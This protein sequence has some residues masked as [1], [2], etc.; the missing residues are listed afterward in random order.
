MMRV[1]IADVLRFTQSDCDFMRAFT[2]IKP[3]NAKDTLDPIAIT[4]CIIANAT[5]LGINKISDS[6]DLNYQ[7]MIS[8]MRNFIRLETLQD[9]ND[10]VSNAIAKLP[11]FQYW[12]IHHDHIH[13][14]VDGQKFETRLHSFIAR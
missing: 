3:Y 6:S 9:A 4:A 11:I 7:R 14:S 12:N 10:L 2:H 1:S 13:G 8:Q 5:N